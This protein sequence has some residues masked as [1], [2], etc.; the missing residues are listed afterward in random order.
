MYSDLELTTGQLL[1][2]WEMSSLE[3]NGKMLNLFGLSK[4][5]RKWFGGKF[6]GKKKKHFTE[7][8]QKVKIWMRV[9]LM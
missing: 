8:W 4:N 3:K 5:K 7:K 6:K 1:C 9:L 2:S